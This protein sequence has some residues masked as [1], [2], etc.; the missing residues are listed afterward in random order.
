M[1]GHGDGRD[2]PIVNEMLGDGL[3]TRENDVGSL[4]A[5]SG[6]SIASLS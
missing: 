1:S 3:A 6:G 4:I 5:V 2:D